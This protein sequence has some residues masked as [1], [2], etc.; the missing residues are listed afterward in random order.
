MLLLDISWLTLTEISL[1]LHHTL[2]RS[3]GLHIYISL[4]EHVQLGAFCGSRAVL[5][6]FMFSFFCV[7]SCILLLVTYAALDF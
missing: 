5:R 3:L 1:L 7:A 2:L 6:G 4:F